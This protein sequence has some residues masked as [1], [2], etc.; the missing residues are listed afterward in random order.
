MKPVLQDLYDALEAERLALLSHNFAELDEIIPIKTA[1]IERLN[2]QTE[3]PKLLAQIR[4]SSMSNA[5]ILKAS[6]RGI[7]MAIRRVSQLRKAS[8]GST[9][10]GPKGTT[11]TIGASPVA[12]QN[13]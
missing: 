6:Q 10:Y 12:P 4:E 13:R 2:N 9:V 3:N 1:L 11:Q 7:E 8:S 5:R